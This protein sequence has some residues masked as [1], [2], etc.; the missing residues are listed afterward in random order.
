MHA[1]IVKIEVE[2]II[3][4]KKWCRVCCVFWVLLTI[5]LK[6]MRPMHDIGIQVSVIK[7]TTM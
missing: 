6:M 5:K 2:P 4:E 3:M 1:M 7:K